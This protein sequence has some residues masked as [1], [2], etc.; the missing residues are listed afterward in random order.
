MVHFPER[1]KDPVIYFEV[2]AVR[3]NEPLRE[4]GKTSSGVFDQYTS[5]EFR[6]CGI[7]QFIPVCRTPVITVQQNYNAE[8]KKRLAKVPE[9]RKDKAAKPSH[10]PVIWQGAYVAP[11]R[12]NK[13]ASKEDQMNKYFIKAKITFDPEKLVFYFKE[14]LGVPG[15]K[16]PN[17]YKPPK[18][19]AKK[20]DKVKKEDEPAPVIKTFEELNIK[21]PVKGKKETPITQSAE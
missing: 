9:E 19:G 6:A 18:P 14:L 21:P 12:H 13:D 16:I 8:F 3:I 10:L 2:I 7:W 20:K 4:G 5:G 11:S 15:T 1:D 17:G